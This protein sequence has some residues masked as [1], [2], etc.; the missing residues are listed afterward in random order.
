MKLR[1]LQKTLS[2]TLLLFLTA[3]Y[4]KVEKLPPKDIAGHS[5]IFDFANQKK[6]T[7]SNLTVHFKPDLTYTSTVADRFYQE[8]VYAYNRIDQSSAEIEI[9]IVFPDGSGTSIIE[10]IFDTPSQGEFYSSDLEG[11]TGHT[12]G[13][14]TLH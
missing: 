9:S 1:H 6:K 3:C 10:L 13:Q 5:I 12:R 7:P 14:F 11:N 4:A 8:G 2:L